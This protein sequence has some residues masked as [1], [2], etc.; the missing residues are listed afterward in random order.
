MSIKWFITKGQ[1]Y[2]K[3]EIANNG[4]IVGGVFI[5]GRI[6]YFK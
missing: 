3:I 4:L 1:D 5:Q 6:L 2:N